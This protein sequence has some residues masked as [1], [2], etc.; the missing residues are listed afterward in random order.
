MLAEGAGGPL[1][2][3]ALLYMPIPEALPVA[4][5]V[6]SWVAVWPGVRLPAAPPVVVPPPIALAPPTVVPPPLAMAPPPWVAPPVNNPLAEAMPLAATR[7]PCEV[8]V[9]P[10]VPVP[11]APAPVFDNRPLPTPGAPSDR[12]CSRA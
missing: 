10:A 8:M 2:G 3:P 1:P 7:V 9:W 12:F 5:A 4:A 6:V 11:V